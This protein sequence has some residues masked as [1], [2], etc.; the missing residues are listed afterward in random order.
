[1]NVFLNYSFLIPQNLSDPSCAAAPTPNLYAN[2]LLDIAY[3]PQSCSY[4]YNMTFDRISIQWP[5][6][7]T[8]STYIFISTSCF[9]NTQ[10]IRFNHFRFV[11]VTCLE[12]VFKGATSLTIASAVTHLYG[13][14]L[15]FTERTF[16][17]PT[18]LSLSFLV[19]IFCEIELNS[20]FFSIA[21]IS[22][23]N[24]RLMAG[25]FKP[26]SVRLIG[27]GNG[28]GIL[29]LSHPLYTLSLNSEKIYFLSITKS[30]T[31]V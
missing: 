28:F 13:V 25:Y 3:S 18:K 23:S 7:F 30:N 17:N 26:A 27:G 19:L 24:L 5:R 21:S 11:L 9:D 6:F 8:S 31:N 12:M 15:T 16:L 4:P 22:A 20:L 10:T 29:S 1:M 14:T 2:P